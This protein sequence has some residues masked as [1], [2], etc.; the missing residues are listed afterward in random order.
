MGIYA[1]EEPIEV[2]GHADT[3]YGQMGWAV[4]IYAGEEPMEVEDH[5]DTAYGQRGG[6][7]GYMQARSLWK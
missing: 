1:G 7:V 6:A 3:A 2:E 4:G 5:A